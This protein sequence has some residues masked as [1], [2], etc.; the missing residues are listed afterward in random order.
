MLVSGLRSGFGRE[1][2]IWKLVE[3]G[4]RPGEDVAQV[5]I[6]SEYNGGTIQ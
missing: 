3:E 1:G 6:T 5:R 2:V 4:S